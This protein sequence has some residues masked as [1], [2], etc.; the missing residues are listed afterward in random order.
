MNVRCWSY[1]ESGGV[2]TIDVAPSMLLLFSA[3]GGNFSFRGR[4]A[5]A[6]SAAAV[7]SLISVAVL[8]RDG[9]LS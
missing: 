1:S 5:L 3:Y 8:V 4:L 6:V 9:T 2:L 7:I